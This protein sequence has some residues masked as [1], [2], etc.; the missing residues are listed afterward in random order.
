MEHCDWVLENKMDG[1]PQGESLGVEYGAKG[2]SSGEISG[3][4]LEGT[5]LGESGTDVCS[6]GE[7]SGGNEYGMI[8]GSPLG[9]K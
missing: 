5:E 1:Y 7:M 6:P 3:G 9:D 4:K 2:G 8:E